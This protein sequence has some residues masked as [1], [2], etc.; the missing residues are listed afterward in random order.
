MVALQK[1]LTLLGVLVAASTCAQAVQSLI[2]VSVNRRDDSP[3]NINT[4]G[5]KEI[6]AWLGALERA[7]AD[8]VCPAPCRELVESG[9]GWA[10]YQ[11][12]TSLAACNQTMLVDVVYQTAISNTE[13]T[14]LAL[15]AC[16]ADYSSADVSFQPKADVA[17]L[18]PTPNHAMVDRTVSIVS[19]VP[20]A[21]AKD[22]FS[23]DHLL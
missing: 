1:P 9:D 11:D 23:T 2:P 16:V 8:T 18:C 13:N 4:G 17:A 21:K 3:F 7:P 12:Q 5:D 10:M 22:T 19:S 6:E 15:R 20:G 14:D